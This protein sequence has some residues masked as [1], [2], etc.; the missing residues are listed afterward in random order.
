MGSVARLLPLSMVS[1]RFGV[2]VL[3]MAS[4]KLTR[5]FVSECGYSTATELGQVRNT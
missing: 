5:G 3:L 1:G 2:P 4:G